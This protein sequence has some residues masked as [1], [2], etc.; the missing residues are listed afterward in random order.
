MVNYEKYFMKGDVSMSIIGG[1]IYVFL[2]AAFAKR[3]RLLGIILTT[4]GAALLFS[5][6]AYTVMIF[7]IS[8]SMA[9][10]KPVTVK[11]ALE[12]APMIASEYGTLFDLVGWVLAIGG[13]IALVLR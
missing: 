5:K 11:E 2:S 13:F 10:G 1:I 8:L 3:L 7:G 9:L 6:T 12:D 4:V